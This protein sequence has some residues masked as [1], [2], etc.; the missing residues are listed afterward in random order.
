[1]KRILI[2][3]L[4]LVVAG[5][6]LGSA[7]GSL[8]PRVTAA[9]SIHG[10][11]GAFGPLGTLGP[12][13]D[14]PFHPSYWI[15]GAGSS[16]WSDRERTLRDRGGPLSAAGPLGEHGALGEQGRRAVPASFQPGGARSVLGSAGP[17][18]PH[19]ALGPL[20]PIGA[21]GFKADRHGDYRDGSTIVR[22]VVV[23]YS[24]TQSREY[25][26]FEV[27][28]SVTLWVAPP[29]VRLGTYSAWPLTL[30]S[31]FSVNNLPK[32]AT[33]TFPGVRIVS[34]VLAPVRPLSK[35]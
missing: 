13:G 31:R 21:H 34:W 20:G 24:K 14:T 30:A 2:A 11:L 1:M 12:V 8:S 25:E 35:C 32:L 26:L 29:I 19:G 28:T 33:L 4:T 27:Y 17:L 5:P 6:A 3:L 22:S 16:Q 10:P 7:P 18:G 9:A 23:R 15:S